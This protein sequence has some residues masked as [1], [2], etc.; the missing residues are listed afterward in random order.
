V[1]IH[2]K[3]GHDFDK[4][5]KKFFIVFNREKIIDFVGNP[6]VSLDQKNI[7][8]ALNPIT[9]EGKKIL[10]SSAKFWVI[11]IRLMQDKITEPIKQ[12]LRD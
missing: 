12:S 11:F 10:T 3:K 9:K 1:P 7:S 2:V 4:W 8:F 6:S 5:K